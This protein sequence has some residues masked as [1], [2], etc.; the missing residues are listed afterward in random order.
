MHL[1]PVMPPAELPLT[2][3]ALKE[4]LRV[5]GSD[6]N[7]VIASY[8]SAALAYVDGRDGVLGRALVEQAWAVQLD[9]GFPVCGEPIRMPLPPLRDV[10]EIAYID[11]AGVQQVLDASAYEVLTNREPGEVRPAYGL[12]WPTTRCQPSAVT[13]TFTAGFGDADAVPEDYKHLLRFLVAHWYAQREPVTVG[14]G[15]S[16]MPL[17]VQALIGKLRIWGFR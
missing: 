10:T 17:S 15:I 11:P 16:S 13:I 14:G 8:L 6:D 4:H 3:D 12:T 2:I 9:G 7:A 5:D 1:I